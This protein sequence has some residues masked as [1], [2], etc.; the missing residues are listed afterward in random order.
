VVKTSVAAE[1]LWVIRGLPASTFQRFT[2]QRG[3]APE[4]I[5]PET[6]SVFS[7]VVSDEQH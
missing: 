1:P 5:F 4:A 6:L 2:I 7:F 3:G